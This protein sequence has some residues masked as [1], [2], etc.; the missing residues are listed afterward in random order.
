MFAVTERAILHADV[1]AFFA[2]VAQRDEAQL[3]GRPVIVGSWVV[4]AASYE[5]RA[6]GVTGGMSTARALRQCP[7]AVVVDPSWPAYVESSKAVFEIFERFSAIVEPGS[8]D[9]AFLL[10]LIHI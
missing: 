1:D 2:S 6:Y 3:R 4:M 8:M 10:S 7:R 9:E 5:A